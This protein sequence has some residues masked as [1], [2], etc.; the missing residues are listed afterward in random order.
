[1]SF[2]LSVV[3]F[4]LSIGLLVGTSL[5]AQTLVIQTPSCQSQPCTLPTGTNGIFYE[6]GFGASGGTPTTGSCTATVQ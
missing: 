3:I 1:M 6:S 5:H 4:L 2:R